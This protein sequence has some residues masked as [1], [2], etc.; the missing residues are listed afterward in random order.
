M[1]LGYFNIISLAD[2]GVAE[3]TACK[4]RALTADADYHNTLCHSLVLLFNRTERTYIKAKPAA[5][6]LCRV[7]IDA[8]AVL[9]GDGGAAE[10]HTKAAPSA[11]LADVA[12]TCVFHSL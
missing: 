6:T 1:N 11:L 10:L 12:V 2:C 4:E 3:N 8:A 5:V 9:F 7:D